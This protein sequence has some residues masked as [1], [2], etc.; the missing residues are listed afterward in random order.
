MHKKGF[1]KGKTWTVPCS[2]PQER[3]MS[4]FVMDI[5]IRI[6][7]GICWRAPPLIDLQP[8]CPSRLPF[9]EDTS[10]RRFVP[11]LELRM[12]KNRALRV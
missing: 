12:G 3:I 6:L 8:R 11:S 1:G 9:R 10:L 2:H 4:A 5:G 7:A